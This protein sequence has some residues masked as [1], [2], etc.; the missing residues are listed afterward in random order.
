MRFEGLLGRNGEY[1]REQPNAEA[2]SAS[3]TEEAGDDDSEG[4][5]GSWGASI[6]FPM[7]CKEAC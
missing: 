3:Q 2:A 1:E 7:G 6:Y 4:S 5:D